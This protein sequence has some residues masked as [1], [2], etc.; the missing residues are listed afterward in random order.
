MNRQG[1]L[2]IE[3]TAP[4][5]DNILTKIAHLVEEA[6]GG[7]SRANSGSSASAH[8]TVRPCSLAPRS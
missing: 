6:Q 7:K 3:A 8:A 2:E 5:A 4:F 1:A